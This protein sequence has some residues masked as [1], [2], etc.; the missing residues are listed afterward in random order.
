MYADTMT[1]SMKKCIY[2]TERRRVKQ[3]AFN[4]EHNITPQTIKKEIRKS[5]TEQVKARDTAR[6]AVHFG[7][8]EFEKVEIATQIEMNFG[9]RDDRAATPEK[10]DKFT[11]GGQLGGTL[12]NATLEPVADLIDDITFIA[13]TLK[14]GDDGEVVTGAAGA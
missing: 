9:T 6:K 5:L 10:V 4:K 1:D 3:L 7:G 14:T 11:P 2:E 12:G 13:A 8:D